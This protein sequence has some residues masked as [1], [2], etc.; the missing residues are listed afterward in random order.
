MAYHTYKQRT[1]HRP[2]G[3]SSAAQRCRGGPRSGAGVRGA[4]RRVLG[5][6][7]LRAPQGV[8]RWRAVPARVWCGD[9]GIYRGRVVG[10]RCT[11]VYTVRMGWGGRTMSKRGYKG[12]GRS[13]M[14]WAV[15]STKRTHARHHHTSTTHGTPSHITP[16]RQPPAPS[17]AAAATSGGVGRSAA[18]ATTPPGYR[19]CP[20]AAA[21]HTRQ[22]PRR[23]RRLHPRHVGCA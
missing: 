10:W 21:L 6:E 9:G 14:R 1:T 23:P 12:G 17:S 15:V 19:P 16:P 18:P 2:I 11:S 8:I 4:P 5:R 7:A 22:P 20:T 13:M 3:W